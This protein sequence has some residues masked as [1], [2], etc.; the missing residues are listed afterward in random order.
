VGRKMLVFVGFAMVEG[1]V[2]SVVKGT[3]EGSI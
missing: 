3:G 2:D 1:T